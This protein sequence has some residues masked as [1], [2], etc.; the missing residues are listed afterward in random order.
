MIFGENP[1]ALVLLDVLGL[2]REDFYRYRD[3]YLS[4][5]GEIAVYTRG[6]GNN[7]DCYCGDYGHEPHEESCVILFHERNREHPMYLRDDDDS[8]D[9]TYATHYFSIPDDGLDREKLV[10]IESQLARDELWQEFLTALKDK[11][12]EGR[13]MIIRC[14]ADLSAGALVF[15]VKELPGLVWMPVQ[16]EHMSFSNEAGKEL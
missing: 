3:C 11:K 7:R 9:N 15:Q 16:G 13:L 8:F 6:G 2:T 5:R 1:G 12:R 10:N 14:V 4:E